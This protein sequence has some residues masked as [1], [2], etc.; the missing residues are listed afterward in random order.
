MK[1]QLSKLISE[2]V[3]EQGIE[4]DVEVS[5]PENPANGDYSTNVALRVSKQLKN[6]PAGRQGRPMDIALSVKKAIEDRKKH[7]SLN[8]KDQNIKQKD[9]S[10]SHIL[11]LSLIL[12]AIEKVDVAPPGFINVFL[13][14]ASLITSASSVLKDKEAYGTSR[15]KEGEGIMVEY[16]DPNTHKAF[17]IGH[18]RNLSIGESVAR[19]L[20]AVGAQVIHT[21]YQGDVGM[22]IAKCVYALLQLPAISSHLPT[23]RKKGIKEKVDFLGKAYAAG[24][25]K[26]EEDEEIK[27]EVAG[28]NKKIYEKYPSV[29][30]IY[31]ESRQ[32]SLDYFETI[33]KRVGTVYKRNYFESEV[34]ESGKAN[35][36]IGLKKGIFIESDGA[37]IFPGEKFTLHNR[38][39]ITGDGN[40]TYEGK[41]MGLGPLQYND[42]KKWTK[43]PVLVIRV[44]GPEQAGY[45]AVVFEAHSQLF[46][47]LRDKFYHLVAGWV[48]LKQGK[49]SSRSGNVVLGEW[50][51]DE[52]KKS[53]YII[54]E[55]SSASQ[56]EKDTIAE[57]AAVAAVKYSFL[58]VSTQSEIAFDLK[59]SVNLQ[60]DS[61]PY[62]QYT[63]ARCKSVLRKAGSDLEKIDPAVH[64]N[65]EERSVAR[66][67]LY[68][69]DIVAKAAGDLTPSHL[70]TYL[71]QLAQAFNLFY[72]KHSILGGDSAN[73]RLSLTAAT[74]QV[75]AN[76]LYL[77]G[78]E[79]LE[80]M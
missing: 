17:H 65:T 43:N 21:S 36:L 39:F 11:P 79:A 62:L 5:I 19:L 29:Y 59:E 78:I 38:V 47:E 70:C 56:E 54:L 20:K 60:G 48:K 8:S 41:D 55:K 6:L 27:K 51:L 50:L 61:G 14:E 37:I 31:Q 53:I 46:P 52:A 44:V 26:Y 18:L 7:S 80:Q 28:I 24:N 9:Q 30:P 77:L 71:F 63:Y 73:F 2:I 25:S 32:W 49:M 1:A 64:L 74:A 42:L 69:P 35:V 34:S 57:K 72:A 66:L 68:F 58:R 15:T 76:G 13:T 67:I 4:T 10:L 3:K 23:V 22:H 33:Y 45:F 16:G 12:Q 40:P 75:L